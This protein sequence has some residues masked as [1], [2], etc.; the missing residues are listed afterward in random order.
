MS[1]DMSVND[2]P[3]HHTTGNPPYSAV[4]VA[5]ARTLG[6]VSTRYGSSVLDAIV[7]AAVV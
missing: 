2:V 5:R 1:R 3:R 6:L 7:T 4:F